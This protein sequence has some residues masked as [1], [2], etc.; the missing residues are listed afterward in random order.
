MHV[1]IKGVFYIVG[2]SPDADSIKFKADDAGNWDMIKTEHRKRFER[3][4][5]EDDGVVTIRLQAIDA[6]ETHYSPPNVSVPKG[7]KTKAKQVDKPSKGNH[8]QHAEL[9]TQATN[10]FLDFMGARDVEWKRWGRNTWI[11]K[12]TINGRR[13][14]DKF[15]DAI[16]G[17]IITDDIERNGRPIGWVFLGEPPIADGTR[18]SKEQV[19]EWVGKSANYMLIERGTVYPFF[20]MGLSAAIRIPLIEVAKSAQQNPDQDDVW[21]HDKTIEGVDLPSLD[22]LYGDTVVYPYLFRR[23]VRYWYNNMM[24]DFYYKL[25]ADAQTLPDG[26]D[27]SLNLDE[28]FEDGDPWLFIVSTQDFMHLSDV[29]HIERNHLKLDVYPYDM[30]FLS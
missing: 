14:D 17:Y 4:F 2:M 10:I 30:V 1:L 27:L 8:K 26:T 24:D 11:D 5:R 18:L 22:V 15:D 21:T 3:E 29:L 12:A 16:E 20:Y 9:G 6:L 19:G 28:F 7:L 13:V 25:R 23:L